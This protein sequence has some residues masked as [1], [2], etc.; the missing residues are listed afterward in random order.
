MIVI[1]RGK[2]LSECGERLGFF[3][4]S[5]IAKNLCKDMVLKIDDKILQASLQKCAGRYFIYIRRGWANNIKKGITYDI[6]IYCYS[7]PPA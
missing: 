4:P 6:T 2:R 1:V 5:S 3:I 7:A